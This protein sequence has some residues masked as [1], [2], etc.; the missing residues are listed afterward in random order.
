V[1]VVN[2]ELSLGLRTDRD[3]TKDLFGV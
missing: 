2:R 1:R 3:L